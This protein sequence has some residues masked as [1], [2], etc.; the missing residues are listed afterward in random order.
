MF[1]IFKNLRISFFENSKGENIYFQNFDDEFRK[2]ISEKIY[3]NETCKFLGRFLNKIHPDRLEK[4]FERFSRS[5]DAT[6]I[7]ILIM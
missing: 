6:Q 7:E 5:Y 4:V 3:D 2:E 1:L